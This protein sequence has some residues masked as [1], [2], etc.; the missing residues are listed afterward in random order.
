ML[1]FRTETFL[2]ACDTLNYT[3]TAELLHIT[4]PAVSQHISYLE[5]S[6]GVKLFSYRGK[7]LELTE[8]GKMYASS[9]RR[10]RADDDLL[11]RRVVSL[12]DSSDRLFMGATL[13]IA[14]QVMP[15]ALQ[16]LVAAHPEL[17]VSL[18]VDD[19]SVLLELLDEG[20]IDCALI[21]GIFDRSEYDSRIWS[22]ERFCCACA[23]DD[24][25]ARSARVFEDLFDRRL[26]LRESG[27]G[28]RA[29]L[30][31]ALARR[32]FTVE[33]FSQKLETS[34]ISLIRDM[35]VR[36]MGVTFVYEAAVDQAIRSG[37]LARVELREDLPRHDFTFV[38]RKGGGFTDM[39]MEVY[40][41]MKG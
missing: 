19:T 8:A 41:T 33:D 5:R 22:S 2:V 35:A 40:E 31:H 36:G 32:N 23:A 9:C 6:Y 39:F 30:E 7:K 3:R 17:E 28:T 13:T 10:Q 25:R 21:E 11:R 18:R 20:E 15:K 16:K 26:L 12:S 34:S 37:Q 29:L 1:D 4:Q 14:D 38:W 27:S 24:T